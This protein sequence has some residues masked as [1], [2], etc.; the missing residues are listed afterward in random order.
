MKSRKEKQR[1]K[2]EEKERKKKK[3]K[4]FKYPDGGPHPTYPHESK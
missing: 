4:F 2:E 1:K 3:T